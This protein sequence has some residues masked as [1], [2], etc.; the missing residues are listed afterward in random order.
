MIWPRSGWRRALKYIGYRV[1]RMPGTPYS[2]AAGF[3]SG[4]AMSMT[5]FIGLHFILSA[6]LAWLVGGNLLASAF[7]TIVGNPW[8]FPFIWVWTY[9]LGS[10]VLGTG[11]A[12][13]GLHAHLS[14]NYFIQMPKDVLVQ[15][16]VGSAPTA[17]VTWFLTFF[18]MRAIVAGIQERR[19]RRGA[20]RRRVLAH[21]EAGE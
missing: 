13:A 4:A 18:P 8:T 14:W 6:L 20:A 17:F 16:L 7:G 2:I 10:L 15:M 5:P 9:Y 1:I 21:R 11:H 19:R 12:A 3:A